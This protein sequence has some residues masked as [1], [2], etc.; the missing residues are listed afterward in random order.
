MTSGTI[1]EAKRLEGL[2]QTLDS[3]LLASKTDLAYRLRLKPVEVVRS[4]PVRIRA[5]K[6]RSK[7]L[8]RTSRLYI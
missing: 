1:G 4:T 7:A 6:A 8:L 3:A 5:A 2:G